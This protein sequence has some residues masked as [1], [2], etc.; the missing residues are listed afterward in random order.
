MNQRAAYGTISLV[1]F[2][3]CASLSAQS[4]AP[5]CITSGVGVSLLHRHALTLATGTEADVVANRARYVLTATAPD[6]VGVV[7][8]EAVCQRAA[9]AYAR[10][11]GDVDTM[12]VA[13]VALVRYSDSR[14]LV[15]DLTPIV[16]EFAVVAV[17]DASWTL[18][19]TFAK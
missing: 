7:N 8:D 1:V 16:G 19:A 18:L 3:A 6:S 15:S 14:Y 4:R 12:N 11:A 10:A 13:P 2:V 9:Q 17:F 5:F